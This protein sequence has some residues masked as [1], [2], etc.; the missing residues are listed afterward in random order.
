MRAFLTCALCI[1]LPLAVSAKY[2]P[3]ERMYANDIPGLQIVGVAMS[4]SIENARKAVEEQ[5][6]GKTELQMDFPIFV[7]APCTVE[8]S[9][10]SVGMS[11]G[12]GRQAGSD[13]KE[14]VWRDAWSTNSAG[15]FTWGSAVARTYM[16]EHEQAVT[17]LLLDRQRRIRG[18][19]NNFVMIGAMPHNRYAE[20]L[21]YL[22]LNMGGN[23]SLPYAP[24]EMNRREL[25]EL[26]EGNLANGCHLWEFGAELQKRDKEKHGDIINTPGFKLKKLARVYPLL[27]TTAPDFTLPLLDGS[28][29][30]SLS[31]IADGR[32]TVLV[33]FWA[34]FDTG[35]M[36]SLMQTS[37]ALNQ[38]HAIDNLYN[39]WSLKQA[40]PGRK[41]LEGARPFD[42]TVENLITTRNVPHVRAPS[43]APRKAPTT[44]VSAAAPRRLPEGDRRNIAVA[45]LQAKS[46]VTPD[47]A[48]LLTDRLGVELVRTQRVNL[49][50][51]E[52]MNAILAEQG[53][54]QSGACTDEA[55]LVEMGQLLGVSGLVSGSIGKLDKLIMLNVRLIDVGSAKIETVVSEDVEGNISSV[56]SR[57]SGVAAQ[58]AG[59]SVTP[60]PATAATAEVP[61]SNAADDTRAFP[62]SPAPPP[63]APVSESSATEDEVKD[64]D[65]EEPGERDGRGFSMQGI[66]GSRI[67]AHDGYSETLGDKLDFA[68]SG[69]AF[70]LKLDW[71]IRNL[72]AIE[73]SSISTI[74]SDGDFDEWAGNGCLEQ[75]FHAISLTL[76][77][78]PGLA[79]RHVWPFIGYGVGVG[80]ADGKIRSG[81][82]GPTVPDTAYYY[83]YNLPDGAGF[84]HHITA[85]TDLVFGA[86]TFGFDFRAY[87]FSTTGSFD[88]DAP[89]VDGNEYEVN[90]VEDEWN[91]SNVCLL[92]TLGLSF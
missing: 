3:H 24:T 59:G 61:V 70:G 80:I 20:A 48:A 82:I 35:R 31:K 39:D 47:E 30:S 92:L 49:M 22:L 29:Y 51:R 65:A 34:G 88:D 25:A 56:V 67:F 23:E 10:V 74:I 81:A 36:K 28:G 75:Q 18:I 44:S 26:V 37:M 38:M 13:D 76:K 4:E 71:H 21:E 7:D 87:F 42:G 43:A 73:L 66:F 90:L 12:I 8:G 19:A 53:F 33:L 86:F 40:E 68:G 5:G 11:G 78:N 6:R 72:V 16:V 9:G 57:L 91:W 79:R 1:V 64:D 89:I 60:S 46:G 45:V 62:T 50:E 63:A 2:R 14:N 32:V 69:P 54:Q 77:V 17:V 83:D 52:Q 27:G 58:L 15:D 85:G 84:Q 55:C 41:E